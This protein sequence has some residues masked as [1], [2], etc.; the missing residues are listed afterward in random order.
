MR[1]T[2]KS[3]TVKSMQ[4]KHSYKYN[5]IQTI[6]ALRC[7]LC[8]VVALLYVSSQRALY[9]KDVQECGTCRSAN[10]SCTRGSAG[11]VK[12]CC[13]NA[14]PMTPQLKAALEDDVHD[15]LC[16]CRVRFSRI[17][18]T[19]CTLI[20]V[21]LCAYDASNFTLRVARSSMEFPL[22]DG[23]DLGTVTFRRAGKQSKVF[24]INLRAL[25]GSLLMH[26]TCGLA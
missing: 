22:A 3:N 5:C 2:C 1:S 15:C 16:C 7:L 8:Y 23:R 13:S 17:R 21:Y 24:T 4:R 12:P 6:R 26:C 11:F 14:S 9:N 25:E 10:S 18:S 19:R 20:P